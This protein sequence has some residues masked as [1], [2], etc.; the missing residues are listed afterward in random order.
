MGPCAFRL[1]PGLGQ[2]PGEWFSMGETA[3]GAVGP[4]RGC[5]GRLWAKRHKGT[6]EQV[7]TPCPIKEKE[8]EREK[9]PAPGE[10]TPKSDGSDTMVLNHGLGRFRNKALGLG[11]A[12]HDQ[13]LYVMAPAMGRCV[14]TTRKKSRK[15]KEAV[16]ASG[17][18]EV[19]ETVPSQVLPSPLE[20]VSNESGLPQGPTLPT[21]VNVSAVDDQQ[22]LGHE[23]EAESSHAGDR[24]GHGTGDAELAFTPLVNS[25]VGQITPA[26]T[27]VQA[28][29]ATAQAA[30]T[31][32][33]AAGTAARTVEGR[34]TAEA[35]VWSCIG[36]EINQLEE[37]RRKRVQFGVFHA[38]QSDGATRHYKKTAVF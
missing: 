38:E 5:S 25:S 22:E 14:G 30:Q 24:A 20:P 13:D 18:V 26:Q 21:E 8:K 4:D 29:R 33:R 7:A 11:R 1:E 3:K 37:K 27:A 28:A 31:T 36:W 2:R 23:E 19:D 16:G 34:A 12:D 15:G 17:N 32:A 9:E 10:R 35:E 6:K